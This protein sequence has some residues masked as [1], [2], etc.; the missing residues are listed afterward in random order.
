MSEVQ[1]EIA[2]IVRG[3]KERTESICAYIARQQVPDKHV[4]VIHERPFSQALRK[5]FAIGI[6]MGLD[7]TLCL[8]ADTLLAPHALDSMLRS[9][10]HHPETAFGGH[11]YVLDKFFGSRKNAGYHL[12]R[13]SLL[14][15]ALPLV[16]ETIVSLRP[17]TYV[18]S[19]MEERGHAWIKIDQILAIHDYEQYYRDIYRKMVVRANKSPER[20]DNLL[21]R[22]SVYAGS[23][24]DFLVALWGLRIGARRD[25]HIKLDA[26][27]WSEEAETLLAA[28]G[29][30]EKPPMSDGEAWL[31][32]PEKYIGDFTK[33]KGIPEN[34]AK[35]KSPPS[36][37]RILWLAGLV[38]GRAAYRLQHM[39][40][41]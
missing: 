37:R 15:E 29:V 32:L 6:D 2:V 13:T 25:E 10:R 22:C 33:A 31:T 20:L 9:M 11:G 38:L 14:A 24:T 16:P 35:T 41:H 5:A 39:A 40:S 27:Q 7:W 19:F 34:A 23:D 18:K 12:Y 26:E 17:E 28:H 21:E 3:A 36:V 1:N 4:V 30:E 8:D